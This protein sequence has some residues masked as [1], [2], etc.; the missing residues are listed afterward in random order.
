M[1]VYDR[2]IP[3]AAYS[4]LFALTAGMVIVLIFDFILKNLRAW[5]IDLAG[6]N[7]DLDVG[8][9]IYHRLL[10]APLEKLSGSIGGLA[11][12][13]REF[14]LVKEFF[15]SAT[16]ALV[17]DLPFVFLFILVIYLISGPLAIVP[18]LAVPLV[19]GVGIL[20]QPFIARHSQTVSE[21][22]KSKYGLMVESLAG[23]D[24]I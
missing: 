23:L 7:L 4:S 17:V 18:L 11:N 12:T 13:L 5:F 24:A 3:N 19:L 1:V 9:D 8:E 20:V 15:T 6:H 22:G 14:D 21:T 2:V 16:L 10:R